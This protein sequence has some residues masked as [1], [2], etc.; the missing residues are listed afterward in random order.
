MTQLVRDHIV[1][2]ISTGLQA[3][4]KKGELLAEGPADQTLDRV[5][6]VFEMETD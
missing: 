3:A 1:D 6:D 4:Q 5:H 2:L